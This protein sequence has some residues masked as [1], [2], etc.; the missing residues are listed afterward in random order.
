M[1]GFT[2]QQ[3]IAALV[4]ESFSLKQQSESLLEVA[5]RVVEIGC[6]Q[7]SVSGLCFD[8]IQKSEYNPENLPPSPL[9]QLQRQL[10]AVHVVLAGAVQLVG[11]VRTTV[12]G[13]MERQAAF[14]AAKQ[15]PG[16]ALQ[17]RLAAL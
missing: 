2:K 3:E 15:L 13:L 7:I 17:V 12:L 9:K 11:Q 10:L 6:V 8:L 4:E 5:K 16:R 1:I 14:L